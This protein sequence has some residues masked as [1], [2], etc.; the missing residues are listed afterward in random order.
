MENTIEEKASDIVNW[1]QDA[2]GD[3]AHSSDP[4]DYMDPKWVRKIKKAKKDGVRDIKG[5]LADEYYNDVDTLKDLAGDRI[6][7]AATEL[8]TT[9]QAIPEGQKEHNLLFIKICE[10]MKDRAHTALVTALRSMIREHQKRAQ[11]RGW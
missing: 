1:L 11:E 4:D 10:A 9:T 6:H 2:V 5:W 8:C 7:D 3:C